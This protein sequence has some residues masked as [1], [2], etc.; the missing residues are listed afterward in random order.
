M[1]PLDSNGLKGTFSFQKEIIKGRGEGN[2]LI[3]YI[4]IFIYWY[5]IPE[6]IKS[7]KFI[8]FHYIETNMAYLI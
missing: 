3:S 1:V 8:F 5:H 7:V 4:D 6:T 2:E